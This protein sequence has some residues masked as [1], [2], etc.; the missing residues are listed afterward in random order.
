MFDIGGIIVFVC[1]Y[2]EYWY[3]VWVS[4]GKMVVFLCM[5]YGLYVCEEERYLNWFKDWFY[6]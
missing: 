2:K 3:N 1:I 6:E 5:F 4:I